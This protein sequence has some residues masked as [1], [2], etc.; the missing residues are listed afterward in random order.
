MGIRKGARI[1]VNENSDIEIGLQLFAVTYLG[2][3]MKNEKH[4]YW[5]QERETRKSEK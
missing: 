1:R 4:F 3:V 2:I 5:N